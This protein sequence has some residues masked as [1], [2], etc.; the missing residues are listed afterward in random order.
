MTH[1]KKNNYN[2]YA[3]LRHILASYNPSNFC[4]PAF[5]TIKKNV[6]QPE[7]FAE[8]REFKNKIKQKPPNKTF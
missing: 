1:I 7:Q 2:L 6:T 5:I 4:Q 3:W 8:P